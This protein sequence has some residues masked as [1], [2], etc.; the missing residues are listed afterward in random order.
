MNDFSYL[1]PDQ[2]YLDAACQ[3]LRPLPVINALTEYYTSYNSCG[4]RVKYQWGKVTDEKVDATRAAV[5]KYLKLSSRD[6]VVSFTLNTTYGINLLLDQIRLSFVKKVVTTDIE[7]NS[8]FLATMAF[9]RKHTYVN[10]AKMER[11]VIARNPDGSIPLDATD[12]TRALVVV[13]CASN[14]DGRELVNIKDL[15]KTVHKA[16]GIIIIDAA[17]A[18]AHNSPL[19]HKTEADAICFSGHK[20]YAPSLGVI[21]ARRDLLPK[22]DTTFIGG[23]MVD[24]A[25]ENAYTLSA[26][27]PDHA[28]TKFE[29]GLQAWGEIIALGTALKWLESLPKSAHQSLAAHSKDLFDFL[30]SHPKVHLINHQPAPTMSLFVEGLDSHLAGAALSRENIM[31]RTGYFCCHY[32]L[33]HKLNLPPLIRFSLGH[34]T[35][36]TDIKKTIDTLSKVC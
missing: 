16:G 11:E 1:P 22:I 17:Q 23:G 3:S 29:S 2:I 19:L 9:A 27:N 25:D 12:W 10:K 20:I 21:V 6:H 31:A 32:Y 24:D 14:I 18:M 34:H 35:R 15:V 26:T 4:E 7:H 36:P 5:L 8:P 28:Y 13:N 30:S 33:A